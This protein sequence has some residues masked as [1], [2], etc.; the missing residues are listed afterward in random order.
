MIFIRKHIHI[1]L[2]LC[3]LA[4]VIKPKWAEA[5]EISLIRFGNLYGYLRLNYNYEQK[6]KPVKSKKPFFKQSITLRNKG[7]VISPKILEFNW[8]A[9][10]ALTQEKYSSADYHHKSNGTFLNGFFNASF[11]KKNAYP[12]IF[13][14]SRDKDRIAFDYGGSTRFE[15]EKMHATFIANKLF[16]RSVLRTDVLRLDEEWS[17]IDR[18]TRRNILRRNVNYNGQRRGDHTRISLTYKYTDLNDRRIWERSYTL[19]DGFLRF[20]YL[21]SKN[22]DNG[23][24]SN[25]RFYNRKGRLN[26]QNIRTD[27]NIAFKL[28]F[29][30]SNRY[31]Y[32]YSET[33]SNARHSRIHIV[34][35]TLSHQLYQSINS[36]IG[37]GLTRNTMTSGKEASY[38]YD[39]G[40]NYTK[41]MPFSGKLQIGYK[42]AH[43]RTDRKIQS[44]IY[45]IVAE[46]H[47]IFG[48]QPVFLNE[49][50]I[51]VSSI[52]VYNESGDL[53]YEEG[54]NKDYTIE[55]I[56]NMVFIQRSPFSRIKP[57]QAILV[58]YQFRT[59][60]SVTFRTALNSFNSSLSFD[61]LQL[62]Y[63]VNQHTQSLLGGTPENAEF[64]QN[65]FFQVTGAKL[66]LRGEKTGVSLLA[67]QRLYQTQKQDYQQLQ[68]R[69]SF[70]IRLTEFLI[71]SSKLSFIMLEYPKLDQNMKIYSSRLKVQWNPTTVFAVSGF[72]GIRKQERTTNINMQNLEFGG[73]AQW[74]W[75]TMR[76]KIL[77]RTQD[78]LYG[79]RKT[80]FNRFIVEF[81]RY[82]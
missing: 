43:G 8:N 42:R 3:L 57:E 4:I 23:W 30:F 66:S 64:M 75:R 44:T 33:R 22:N 65:I 27:N 80:V 61:W 10:M 37:G 14:W 46:Y 16:L 45:P 50:N 73:S 54:E 55:E 1:Y 28:P 35:G 7:Y 53:I 69:N 38:S 72:A 76:L 74:F 79:E 59:L 31:L 29:G 13:S 25:V 15:I 2:M 32:N 77:Y 12:F 71:L 60:P 48:E 24:H 17:Q 56:D 58:D 47:L 51:I 9:T 63:R 41:K 26:Y 19:H 40:I 34:Y 21:F 81:Q 36:H 39:W 6:I 62:Y 20:S 5:Q 82:F 18:V 68:L 52:I 78:W 11:F 49:R 70:Y 67:E